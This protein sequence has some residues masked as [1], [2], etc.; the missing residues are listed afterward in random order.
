MSI[1]EVTRKTS[2]A[3]PPLHRVP[4]SMPGFKSFAS[5]CLQKQQNGRPTSLQALSDPWFTG[6]IS[7]TTTATPIAS[8]TTD[9]S[10]VV[11]WTPRAIPTAI[12]VASGKSIAMASGAQL[13]PRTPSFAVGSVRGVTPSPVRSVV[14]ISSGGSVRQALYSPRKVGYSAGSIRSNG[15]YVR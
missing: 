14:R 13:T 6:E 12:P 4:A 10:N 7:A 1:E 5:K 9:P 8:V 2:T 3:Y 11:Q 15:V